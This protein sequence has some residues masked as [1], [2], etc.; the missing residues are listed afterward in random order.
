M[1]S[2][3]FHFIGVGQ[4]ATINSEIIQRLGTVFPDVWG[5]GNPLD[6]Q[7]TTIDPHDFPQQSLSGTRRVINEPKIEV[8]EN[9]SFADNYSITHYG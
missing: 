4:G 3:P 9:V 2:S 8:W 7:M 6:L 1:F 5:L